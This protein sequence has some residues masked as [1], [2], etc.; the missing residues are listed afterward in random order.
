MKED[1]MKKVLWVLAAAGALLLAVA[2]LRADEASDKA[3]EK[4]AEQAARVWLGSLDA[5]DYAES[6]KQASSL[7]QSK[8]TEE[9]W[10]TAARNARGPYGKVLSRKVKS[11]QFERTLPYAPDGEYVVIQYETSFEN[12]KD[13]VETVTPMK[14]KDGAWKVSGYYVR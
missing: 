2:A 13:A 5:G 11:A 4:A 6:W 7:F 10:K 9:Q 1:I 3:A 14:E 12:K 8:V